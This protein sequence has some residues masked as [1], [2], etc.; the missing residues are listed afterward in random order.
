MNYEALWVR[1]ALVKTRRGRRCVIHE[2]D[3]IPVKVLKRGP[4]ATNDAGPGSGGGSKV[5]VQRQDTLEETYVYARNLKRRGR[6]KSGSHTQSRDR[7]SG[8]HCS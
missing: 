2:A 1:R 8:T 5:R 3:E 7:G 6:A 4:R